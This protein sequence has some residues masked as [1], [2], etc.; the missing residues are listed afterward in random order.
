MKVYPGFDKTPYWIAKLK[1]KLKLYVNV[2]GYCYI[3]FE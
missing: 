2:T 1:K 3:A